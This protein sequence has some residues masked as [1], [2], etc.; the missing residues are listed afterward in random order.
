MKEDYIGVDLHVHTPASNCYKRE[1]EDGDEDAEYISLIKKYVDKNIKVMAITDHNSIEGYIKIMK[2][3]EEMENSIKTLERFKHLS[4]IQKELE[5]KV[6]ILNLFNEILILP[7]VEFDANP[8]VHLLLVFNPREDV[9]LIENFLLENGYSKE[10][11]GMDNSKISKVSAIEII[12][13]AKSLGAITIAAHIES[14]KGALVNIPKGQGR[15]Q[16]LR[17]PSLMA[18]QVGNLE[19]IEYLK[20]LYQ[21]KEY[22]REHLPA[23]VRCSDFHNKDNDIENYVT[24]MKLPEVNFECIKDLIS[25]NSG[26]ISFTKQPKNDEVIKGILEQMHTYTIDKIN[27]DNLELLKKYICCILNLGNGNI[28][29]GRRNEKNITAIKVNKN[30]IENFILRG[31]KEYEELQPF[32]RYNIDYFNY[33][34][35]WIA[36]LRIKTMKKM[37]YSIQSKV[38]LD[39]NGVIIEASPNEIAEMGANSFKKC[40]KEI[41]RRNKYMIDKVTKELERI[42]LLENNISLYSKIKNISLNLKDIAEINIIKP[43]IGE[44]EECDE[45]IY[46]ETDGTVYKVDYEGYNGVHTKEVYTR[47][48]CPRYRKLEVKV[49]SEVFNDECILVL[50]KGAT[51]YIEG[52]TE[53]KIATR[54]SV[55]RI[56]LKEEFKEQ[57]SLKN[58]VMWLKS[59]VLISVI[60]L[61]YGSIDIFYPK[62]LRTIPI[63]MDDITKKNS[64][65][66]E[67]IDNI[68]QAE[69]EFLSQF[70]MAEEE[71]HEILVAEHNAKVACEVRNIEMKIKE[72]LNLESDEEKIIFTSINDHEWQDIFI[73]K[74]SLC[75]KK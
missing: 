69:Y 55:F 15:A 47:I 67:S 53:Y 60:E 43:T 18:I 37:I 36:V 66:T 2:I 13:K 11:Q 38:Y 49:S 1:C 5:E 31:I 24:Y 65:L 34:N 28:V 56:V 54:Y 35:H 74:E 58:I 25:G 8:G 33:G 23:F 63:I 10:L 71:N 32:F 16:F 50:P 59:P 3:K 72:S 73:E 12:E 46:G 64:E 4:E 30:D 62:I 17:S 70:N 51:H 41:N 19:K 75:D 42:K 40:F 27:S 9:K 44:K 20:A 7:G 6:A 22:R 14:S 21:S 26:A 39:K 29:L 45:H 68:I 57:F 48:T 52:G 61:L